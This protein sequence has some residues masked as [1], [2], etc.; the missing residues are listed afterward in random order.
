MVLV[1]FLPPGAVPPPLKKNT[2]L[3]PASALNIQCPPSQKELCILLRWSCRSVKSQHADFH[4]LIVALIH[5]R[6]RAKRPLYCAQRYHIRPNVLIANVLR[7]ERKMPP[8][9]STKLQ[10]C[11]LQYKKPFKKISMNML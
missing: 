10:Y 7:Q 11:T 4:V 1:L 6:R 5:L 2:E 3:V 8:L 9:Y